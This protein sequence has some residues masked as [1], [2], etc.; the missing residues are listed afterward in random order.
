MKHITATTAQKDLIAIINDVTRNN[1]P[2]TC[3]SQMNAK[4]VSAQNYCHIP[5]R[6]SNNMENKIWSVSIAI[7]KTAFIFLIFMAYLY[8]LF[9]GYDYYL[10]HGREVFFTLFSMDPSLQLLRTLYWSDLIF[11]S[12]HGLIPLLTVVIMFLFCRS[13]WIHINREKSVVNNLHL[14]TGILLSGIATTAVL[15]FAYIEY[16]NKDSYLWRSINEINNYWNDFKCIK[17]N[18]YY[19]YTGRMD[20]EMYDS[21]WGLYDNRHI[22]KKDFTDESPL[23]YSSEGV[24]DVVLKTSDQ[25]Y[26]SIEKKWIFQ[27][28]VKYLPTT[29]VVVSI[30]RHISPTEDNEWAY[31]DLRYPKSNG[32]VVTETGDKLLILGYE[33]LSLQQQRFFD[34][35]LSGALLIG[36]IRTT[37][38]PF[39]DDLTSEERKDVVNLFDA[40]QNA[41][42]GGSQ[43]GEYDYTERNNLSIFHLP[44][45]PERIKREVAFAKKIN[46]IIAALPTNLTAYDKAKWAAEY[47]VMNTEYSECDYSRLAYGA[48]INGKSVCTGYAQAYSALL[49]RLGLPCTVVSANLH[50]WN[51][52]LIDGQFFSVD[53]TWMDGET[54]IRY[55]YFMQQYKEQTTQSEQ[56]LSRKERFLLLLS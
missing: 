39:Y 6:M 45:I 31:G 40:Y 55:E 19:T 8:G 51:I 41:A 24:V 48:L 56:V 36:H 47:I 15:G 14:I 29:G 21:T 2:V 30:N 10:D 35:L 25:L 33:K 5:E 42:Y 27:Y 11:A 49:Y 38:S 17:Q 34:L 44:R 18:A 52:V 16:S 46:N 54:E 32:L 23:F 28:E 43:C 1:E 20:W 53:T 50:A 3:K 13:A 22:V 4:I 7:L 37:I 26:K 12:F 9:I